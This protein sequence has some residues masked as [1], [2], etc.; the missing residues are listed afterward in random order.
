MILQF[1]ADVEVVAPEALRDEIRDEVARMR[2]LYGLPDSP[3]GIL[4]DEGVR[5]EQH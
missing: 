2:V 4:T 5:S 1:G 3:D